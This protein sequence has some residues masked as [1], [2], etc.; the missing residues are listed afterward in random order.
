MSTQTA[1]PL[2]PLDHEAQTT[3]AFPLNESGNARTHQYFAAICEPSTGQIHSDQIV[4]ST[5]GNNY[6]LVVYN[7]DSNSILVE[8]LCNCTDPCILAAFTALHARFVPAGLRIQLHRL[9]NECS[10]ALKTFLRAED[11]DY[12]LVPPKVHWRNAAERAI[13]TFKN[14]FVAGLCSVDK[15]HCICGTN[16][17]PKLNLRSICFGGRASTLSYLLMHNCMGTWI[18]TK[19]PSRLPASA[20][21]YTSNL[22]NA[23]QGRHTEP[24]AGTPVQRSSPTNV[25]R[26]GS[27]TQEP[28]VFATQLHGSPPKSPC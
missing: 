9:D 16:Y 13:R 7:Y 3:D 5:T 19:P 10:D 8:P 28:H 18:S 14:N 24:T 1:V 4:T 22:V 26:Y 15:S 12:Q 23:Q 2:P 17:S 11:M 20:S 6:V 21:W 25:T 27:G